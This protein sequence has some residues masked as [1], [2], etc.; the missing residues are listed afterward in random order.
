MSF[1]AP[2]V[3]RAERNGYVQLMSAPEPK[4]LDPAFFGGRLL[5][6]ILDWD[7]KLRV[8]IA[9]G[10]KRRARL[11][12]RVSY[13]R[14]FV[15]RGHIRAPRELRGKAIKVTL[16][17][18]GP[19]VRFGHRGL[20]EVGHLRIAATRGDCDFEAMLML[21][22]DAIPGTAASLATMWKN[23]QILTFDESAEGASVSHYFFGVAIH[24]N[25]EAWAK[26]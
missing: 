7:W 16:S 5:I 20:Q 6:D 13:G 2:A 21:P 15:I 12:E 19:K 14:D 10:A 22:Q 18:F 9:A 3:V 24:P 26:C 4:A 17:P 23:L 1:D 11:S 8:A 25:L